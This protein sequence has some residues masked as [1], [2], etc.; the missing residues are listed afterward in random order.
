MTVRSEAMRLNKYLADGR[1]VVVVEYRLGDEV[2]THRITRA[3]SSK[4]VLQGRLLGTGRW[5]TITKLLTP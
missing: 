1:R 2:G 4:G 5:A 3:R